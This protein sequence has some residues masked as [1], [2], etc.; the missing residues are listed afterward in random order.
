MRLDELRKEALISTK[1]RGHLMRWFRPYITNYRALQLG[2]CDQCGAYVAL[3]T[4][5]LPNGID[6]GGKAVAV[7]C[8]D[9]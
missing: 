9:R 2:E 8:G 7:N 4:K 6:I 3:D 5:P 1:H